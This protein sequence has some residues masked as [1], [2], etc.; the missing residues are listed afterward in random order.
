[1]G[2]GDTGCVVTVGERLKKMYVI[3]HTDEG[4][5]SSIANRHVVLMKV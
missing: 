2:G 1:V 5:S 4:F 3:F